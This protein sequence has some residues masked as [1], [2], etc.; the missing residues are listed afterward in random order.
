MEREQYSPSSQESSISVEG[1][2]GGN[3]KDWEL[4]DQYRDALIGSAIRQ[5]VPTHTAED[6]VQ[7]AFLKLHKSNGR[8]DGNPL[9]LLYRNL[10]FEVKDWKRREYGMGVKNSPPI[11]TSLELLSER[12]EVFFDLN[13]TDILKDPSPSPEEIAI[14]NVTMTDEIIPA[15]TCLPPAQQ[16]VILF[17]YRD[18]YTQSNCATILNVPK[19]TVKA[20]IH[21]GLESL[22]SLIA[23]PDAPQNRLQISRYKI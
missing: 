1:I 20:R 3:P 17:T 10:G 13:S 21:R 16:E 11:F 18:G 9:G 6:I 23:P 5:G 12:D 14:H 2:K 4:L 15:L 7:E 22:Y 8:F 19:G